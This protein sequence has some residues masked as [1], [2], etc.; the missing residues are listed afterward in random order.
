MFKNRT[1]EELKEIIL[2][3]QKQLDEKEPQYNKPIYIVFEDATNSCFKNKSRAKEYLSDV[4]FND[5]QTNAYVRWVSK[6]EYDLLSEEWIE[7]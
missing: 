7:S 2:E 3:A 4:A 6:I 1:V 5:E